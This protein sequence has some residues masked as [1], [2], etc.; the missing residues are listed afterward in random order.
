MQ[1]GCQVSV[2]SAV[3]LGDENLIKQFAANR[4]ER[5]QS[6]HD[7]REGLLQIAVEN[8]NITML[9]LLI[10]LGLDPDDRHQLLEYESKPFSWGQPLWIAAGES[11]YQIA[12]FLLEHN[13]DPNASLYASGNPLSRA[14]NNRD[15]KMK[16]L[17]FR[18]GAELDPITAGLEGET[19][20]A[21]VALQSDV[22]LAQDLLWAA[23]CG[24]DLN[25]AGMCLR[26]LDWA[27]DDKRWF[28]LLEQPLRQWRLGPHRKYQ[29]FDRKVYFEIFETILSHGAS[30]NIIGRFGY[31][32]AHHL[33]ACGVVWEEPIMT[34]TD[35]IEF[36]T[37]LLKHKAD[38]NVIDDLLQSTPLGWAVRWGKYELAHLYL[39]NGAHPTLAGAPWATPLHWAEKKKQNNLAKFT[40]LAQSLLTEPNARLQLLQHILNSN[41]TLDGNLEK[42]LRVNELHIITIV[43]TKN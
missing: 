28:N 35:R 39:E 3:A 11:C 24:G 2:E 36:A 30:P 21:A 6:S 5:F 43:P 13:A 33:A 27:N 41:Q 1:A 29:D 4:P 16:G 10:S 42:E 14:Y 40:N 19:S 38:L 31:R 37:I 22:T 17:L 34:E 23:G 7:K 26:H 25:I 12:E 8:G 18:Y 20:A 32:L 9:E 15:E